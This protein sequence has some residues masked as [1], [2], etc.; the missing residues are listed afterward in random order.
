MLNQTII[1][2]Y[3]ELQNALHLETEY[4]CISIILLAIVETTP[5]Y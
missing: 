3:K 4:N 5:N 1:P 2:I